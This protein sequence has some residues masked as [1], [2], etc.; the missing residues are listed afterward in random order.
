MTA[1]LCALLFSFGATTV[2]AQNAQQNTTIKATHGAWEVRCSTENA[3]ACLMAQIGK[4]AEG[5]PVIQV[6]LRKTPNLK[7]PK[8]EPVSAVMEIFAPIGVFLPAGL[9]VKIDGAEV[10]RGI[11][12]YCD[13]RA[14]VVAEPIQDDFIS[15]LKKGSNATMTIVSINNESANITLSLS[16][17]TKAYN[18]L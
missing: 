4:N 14:C 12:R 10:G 18:G 5:A 11:Y 16:G 15:K 7:G 3:S 8:G 17:F 9:A 6:L 2:A 1:A 13:P